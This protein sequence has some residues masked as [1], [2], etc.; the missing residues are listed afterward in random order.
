MSGLKG[1]FT[2]TIKRD[3][4][5]ETITNPFDLDFS[6]NFS[7]DDDSLIDAGASDSNIGVS[8]GNL[9]LTSGS[10]GTFISVSKSVSSDI[11]QVHLK[12]IGEDLGSAAFAVSA[13][14]GNNWQ[15]IN[16]EVLVTVVA[17]GKIL[18]FRVVFSAATA[19]I[20]A[21]AI[22]FK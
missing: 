22:L 18:R 2:D 8:D 1:L 14:D 10:N 12:V 16:A 6:Y 15:V 13:D 3:M 7:F 5:I 19:R 20:D 9:V 11:S 21:A 4:A 17:S